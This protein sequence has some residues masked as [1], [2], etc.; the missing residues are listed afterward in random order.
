MTRLDELKE[1]LFKVLGEMNEIAPV[2]FCCVDD[3][4]VM[5]FSNIVKSEEDNR[6]YIELSAYHDNL[7]VHRDNPLKN[8]RGEDIKP[9]STNNM[10]KAVAAMAGAS[11]SMSGE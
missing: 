10:M 4:S 11:N 8:S 2:Q 1:Q 5:N 9:S 7:P 3:E 6:V